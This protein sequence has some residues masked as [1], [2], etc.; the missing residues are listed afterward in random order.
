MIFCI[1]IPLGTTCINVMVIQIQKNVHAYIERKVFSGIHVARSLVS[2]VFADRCLSFFILPMLSLLR[3][4]TS[5]CPYGIFTTYHDILTC[6]IHGHLRTLRGRR[7]RDRVVVVY[8]YT[9]KL[10]LTVTLNQK[11]SPAVNG[12][13]LKYASDRINM[14]S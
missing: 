13:F 6:C 1:C 14:L 11:T 8:I 2:L 3:F 9:V 5:D 12:Q 10:V 4:T 7:D